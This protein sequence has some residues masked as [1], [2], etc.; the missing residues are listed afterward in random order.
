[1]A[2]VPGVLNIGEGDDHQTFIIEAEPGESIPPRLASAVVEAGWDLYELTTLTA[3]LEDVF[4][5]LV[6]QENEEA[7]IGKRKDVSD[8]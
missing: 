8:A 3:T 5:N 6:T 7:L 2:A 4:I 1:M